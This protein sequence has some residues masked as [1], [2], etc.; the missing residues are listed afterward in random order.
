MYYAIEKGNLQIVRMLLSQNP[1]LEHE[2]K[3]GDTALLRAV[4]NRN[5][6]IVL[7]LL[8]KRAK[9]GATDKRGDTCLHI[10]MRA[11]S[12]AIVEALLHNPKNNQI[13]YKANKVGETPYG[14]DQLHQKTILGQV[15][16]T[17][18]INTEDSEGVL[19]YEVYSSALT[20]ILY[21]PTL[22][23]PI[24]IGLYAK[25][26][27]GKSFLLNKVREE[28]LHFV[29]ECATTAARPT[30]ILLLTILHISLLFGVLTGMLTWSIPYGILTFVSITV[31]V[32]G[33]LKILSIINKRYRFDWIDTLFQGLD[34]QICKLKLILQVAFCYPPNISADIH[35][36][37]VRFHF[38]DLSNAPPKGEQAVSLMLASML[39]EIERHYGTVATRLY[40]ALRPKQHESI[41]RWRFR[42]MC[43]IP[44]VFLFELFLISVGAGICLL[45]IYY[46]HQEL[47]DLEKGAL[48]I[49]LYITGAV[50][51]AALVANF[52]I[53]TRLVSALFISQASHLKRLTRSNNESGLSLTTLG[54]EVTLI[55]DMVKV[56][57]EK[58]LCKM[59]IFYGFHILSSAWTLLLDNKAACVV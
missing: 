18:Q 49:V 32:F 2:T 43:C 17:R 23:T 13:L 19:G 12:K 55:T 25:W 24:T 15:F 39:E 14:I 44:I 10:A 7:L 30:S 59:K 5:L 35:T 45:V 41:N 54:N 21:E 47:N 57:N 58:F 4:R 20:N 22:I 46:T 51:L 53:M 36:K 28:M 1:E 27:S 29:S 40:R 38:A 8:E 6:D 34:K 3:D 56:R 16:G 9:V 11:R 52:H 26:G 42:R 37:P 33:L 50:L 31:V 48:L